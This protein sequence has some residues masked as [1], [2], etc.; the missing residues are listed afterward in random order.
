MLAAT[1]PVFRAKYSQAVVVMMA[2][3]ALPLTASLTYAQSVAPPSPTAQAPRPSDPPVSTKQDAERQVTEVGGRLVI[4]GE[5]VIVPANVDNPSR[6]S[7]IASKIEIPLVETPR[8]VSVTSD[9]VLADR[10]AINI[11]DAH[12][13]TAGVMALDDRGPASVRGFPLGFYDLRR[14]GLRTYSWSVREPAALDRIQYLRGSASVLYGDGSPGG[15][16]NL[17]LKQPLPMRRSE[18]AV[19]LGGLGFKRLTLDTTGP[20]TPARRWR[21]RVIS[22][23]EGLD[24][25]FD[26]NERRLTFLPTL[27]GELND[28][29]TLHVDTE[30]YHQQGRNYWHMVPVTPDTQAGD[31]S[32]IPWDLNTASP[33]DRW[34]GWNASP[35]IRLDA[36]LGETTTLHTAARYTRID[37]D[38]D[39]QGL[40]ALDADGHTAHRFQYREVSTWHELQSDTFVATTWRHG[41]LEHRLAAGVE[42]GLSSTDSAIGVG[43][44]PSLDIY[45]PVYAP[46]PDAPPLR[47]TRFD[48]GRL[49]VYAQDQIRIGS[50]LVVVPALRWS[51]L[52]VDDLSRAA[53]PEG[54]IDTAFSPNLGVVVLPR[55]WLSVYATATRGF[56]APSPGQYSEEG[57]PLEPAT[58]T[59]VESGVKAD[60]SGRASMSAAVFRIRR[61]N[62]PEAD[63]RGFYRQIGEGI[64]R[65]VDAEFA[66]ALAKGLGLTAG[67]AWTRTEITQ[68]SGPFV[69]YDLPNAPRHKAN[70]WLRYRFPGAVGRDA[71]LALGVVHVSSRFVAQDNLV[72]AP[73]FT[74]VDVSGSHVLPASLRI[75]VN[76]HNVANVRY[77]TSGSGGAL[78]AG[79]PRRL[80]VQ[81]SGWF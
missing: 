7:S 76:V 51:R 63:A 71:M 77:V 12:D 48:I 56:E 15:L 23:A 32:K 29:L 53:S 39:I 38:I 57:G 1:S 41:R 44:A 35:G 65:G 46:R 33:D 25:G 10:L 26:N 19:G 73:A 59:L 60:L 16:V 8:S 34:S 55:P 27:A 3:A 70:A 64:S 81:L 14:N 52:S 80:S 74:R 75:A 5:T 43:S 6:E 54:A 30:F 67:Y 17:V 37:G 9:Q 49:G 11:S 69:G 13:Y 21:Y 28:R 47:P 72:V 20:V 2:T 58:N 36:R 4:T 50:Q 31:F 42:A 22:A 40:A 66:G 79:A 45:D 61:T 18:V 24:S 78:Y 68:A 62:V